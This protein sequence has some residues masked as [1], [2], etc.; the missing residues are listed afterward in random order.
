MESKDPSLETRS[1]RPRLRFTAQEPARGDI[2]LLQRRRPNV[3]PMRIRLR[4]R[5]F[6]NN[7]ARRISPPPSVYQTSPPPLSLSSVFEIPTISSIQTANPLVWRGINA[8]TKERRRGAAVVAIVAVIVSVVE[9]REGRGATAAL[10]NRQ[11]RIPWRGDKGVWRGWKRGG[12]GGACA[13][14]ASS[15]ASSIYPWWL[16]P[17]L[18]CS[19]S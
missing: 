1:S 3:Q 13:S 12:G 19:L 10:L 4:N 9:M 6:E 2:Q 11:R 17:C 8:R 7:A 18:L 5:N 14:G 16:P 15:A